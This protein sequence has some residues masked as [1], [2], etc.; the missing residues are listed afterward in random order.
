MSSSQ[1]NEDRV[2]REIRAMGQLE[3]SCMPGLQYGACMCWSTL[4]FDGACLELLTGAVVRCTSAKHRG[5]SE[6]VG[7]QRAHQTTKA[8]PKQHQKAGRGLIRL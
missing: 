7:R 6:P 2:G 1:A 4:V 8:A 3:L 5:I